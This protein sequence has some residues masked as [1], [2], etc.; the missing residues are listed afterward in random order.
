MME[1]A[2]LNH[3]IISNK[4]LPDAIQSGAEGLVFLI[5]KP[6]HWTSFDVVNKLRFALRHSTG[7]KKIKVGH[8]GTLDPLATG[9]LLVCVGKYTKKIDQLTALSKT[10]VADMKL[11][12]TTASYDSECEEENLRPQ[13]VPDDIAVVDAAVVSFKGPIEQVPPLY[14]A[15]KVNGKEAYKIARAGKEVELKKRPVIIHDIKLEAFEKPSAS[16]FID[17]SKGTY[18]RS[19]AHDIGQMLGCGAYLTGLVR[20][21]SGIYLNQDA[22]TVEEAV[23][24]I[25][26]KVR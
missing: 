5:N 24:Y 2:I 26:D 1:E 13:L 23:Q 19:L 17:C 18:I 6:L 3:K 9:L 22:L 12:A 21:S 20:S 7:N 16:L 15:I 10:Y 11:G 8:A 14:S 4:N 25:H